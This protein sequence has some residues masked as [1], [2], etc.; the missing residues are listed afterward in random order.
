M[1]PE[2]N[3]TLSDER[4][5]EVYQRATTRSSRSG[6]I[7]S[8][9]LVAL[10][11]GDSRSDRVAD[12]LGDCAACAEEYRALRAVAPSPPRARERRSFFFAVAT[13]AVFALVTSALVVSL[14]QRNRMLATQLREA[15]DRERPTDAGK[16]QPQIAVVEQKENPPELN[17]SVIDLLPTTAATRGG[18]FPEAT[19]ATTESFT[20]ILH[21]E[22]ETPYSDYAIDIVNERGEVE[23]TGRGLRR[24]PEG[25]FTLHLRRS[26][27]GDGSYELILY[28]LR[29]SA[30]ERIESYTL[31]IASQ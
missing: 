10:A 8:E 20:I 27:F 12:H 29:G 17:V 21:L 7:R 1:K 25:T 9:E 30:K 11:L 14:L 6:C 23:W 26:F 16:P 28:G 3:M 22:T 19:P 13:F 24:S 4:L 18:A 2:S 15:V 31:R 5:R